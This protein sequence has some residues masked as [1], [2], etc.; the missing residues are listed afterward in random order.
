MIYKAMDIIYMG[1]DF[2]KG[3]MAFILLLG[4]P[5]GLFGLLKMMIYGKKTLM[6]LSLL[7][8]G[9]YL[10]SRYMNTGVIPTNLDL[11]G[12]F[13]GNEKDSSYLEVAS[14]IIFIFIGNFGVAQRVCPSCK[15]KNT[16]RLGKSLAGSES[17][18]SGH[19][20]YNEAHSVSVGQVK[21]THETMYQCL[22]CGYNWSETSSSTRNNTK[23]NTY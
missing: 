3:Y 11:L 6:L 8:I 15:S 4:V 2:A 19:T 21:E 14:I 9:T 13:L 18:G 5:Y 23:V 16:K 17:I 7:S 12:T 10:V 1:L 22:D 20:S